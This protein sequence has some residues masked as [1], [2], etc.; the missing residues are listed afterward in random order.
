MKI[1]WKTRLFN[2]QSIIL[3]KSE[4]VYILVEMFS[5]VYLKSVRINIYQALLSLELIELYLIKVSRI[6]TFFITI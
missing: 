6:D 3:K 2:F 1:H 4:N 5:L